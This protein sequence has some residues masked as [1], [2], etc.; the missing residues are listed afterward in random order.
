MGKRRKDII[1]RRARI[2]VPEP[3]TETAEPIVKK[4]KKSNTVQ[5]IP[6]P[7]EPTKKKKSFFNKE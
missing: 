1:R 2:Q 3:T 4:T 5:P 7:A 6:T